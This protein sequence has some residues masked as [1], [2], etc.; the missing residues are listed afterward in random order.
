L[1]QNILKK[2]VKSPQ[3]QEIRPQKIPAGL[4]QLE[5]SS[6]DSRAVTFTY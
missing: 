6:S 5:S 3:R 2:A 4:Q 1:G